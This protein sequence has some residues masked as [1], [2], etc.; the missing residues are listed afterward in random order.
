[1][2]EQVAEFSEEE[3]AAGED[4]ANV[5]IASEQGQVLVSSAPDGLGFEKE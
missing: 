5:E 3:N 1:M 4:S 2:L